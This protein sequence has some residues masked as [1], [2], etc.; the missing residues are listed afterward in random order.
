MQNALYLR[1]RCRVMVPPG[2]GAAPPRFLATMLKNM[3]GLGFTASV[4]L[5]AQLRS[6]SVLQLGRLSLEVIPA[7]QAMVGADVV[8]RPMYP[9]FP[10]QVME[11]SQAELYLHAI[12]HYLTLALPD[13]APRPREPLI[14]AVALR[15]IDLG[16]ETDFLGIC[17]QLLA[18]KRALSASDRADLMWFF[19]TY[20]DAAVALVPDVVPLKEHVALLARCVVRFTSYGAPF[21]GRYVKTAT[22][23]LRIAVAFSDGDVS[24]ARCTRFGVLSR[25]ERRLLLALL[26]ACPRPVEDMV[27]YRGAWV[28]LGERL[29]PGEYRARFPRCFAAFDVLRN[30]RPVVTFRSQVEQALRVGDVARAALVLQARPG[31][32]ARRLD[33]LLRLGAD[34]AA[35]TEQFG[36]VA[37]QVSTPV[38]LQVLAHF[39]HRQSLPALRTFFPKGMVAK[40]Q[41]IPNTLPALGQEDCAVVVAICRETLMVRFR[42]LPPLGRVYVDAQLRDYPVPLTLRS[43]SKALRTIPRGSRLALPVGNTVR[44]FLWWKEG[45]VD[46]RPTGR[47]DIDL[48]AVMYD[49]DWR[50]VEHVSFTH[51][52]SDRY[53]AAHSGDVVAAPDGACEFID[54]DSES[55]VRY[56]GRYV[57]MMV[58]SFTEQPFCTLP[59]CFAGWMV[60]QAPRSGEVF[61]PRTVQDRIDVAAD[62]RICLPLILDLH[63]RKV[64]WADLAL[65]RNPRWANTIEGNQKG[66][67]LMGQALTTLVAPDLYE[68]FVLHAA[69]RG[70]LAD[71]ESADVVFAPDGDV[72]PFDAPLILADYL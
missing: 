11:A 50:Y 39:A 70:V 46:G 36:Q 37:A 58:N 56:G 51:V 5:I 60:R 22:D 34:G 38:L 4:A 53:R 64:V 8:F 32:L 66:M 15:V 54:I 47:V 27:R 63:E 10:D 12:V 55:V 65:R 7:L 24:L 2:D 14:D 1:Q 59:E 40:A 21:I 19:Q 6:L 69:A 25:A 33:H 57:V 35:I 23:V 13:T 48:S 20:G 41:A 30:G 43:A 16:D 26:E 45:V 52:K 28:R 67:L 62:T 9:N 18:A 49:A 61:E 42:A 68:L 71:R 44:F 29:H 17:T 31:E 3:E 72:T